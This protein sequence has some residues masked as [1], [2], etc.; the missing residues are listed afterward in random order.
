[1]VKPTTV[2]QFIDQIKGK[3]LLQLQALTQDEGYFEVKEEVN[4]NHLGKSLK[5]I[6]VWVV[7]V[8][9]NQNGAQV[10]QKDK[11]PV[12]GLEKPLWVRDVSFNS[13]PETIVTSDNSAKFAVELQ[14]IILNLGEAESWAITKFF[15]RQIPVMPRFWTDNGAKWVVAKFVVMAVIGDIMSQWILQSPYTGAIRNLIPVLGF[16]RW[17]LGG[18]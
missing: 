7:A 8:A 11:K 1:M 9:A 10:T 3:T 2:N 4:N 5:I 12:S 13:M 14:E 17:M 6:R 15:M 16:V 18:L